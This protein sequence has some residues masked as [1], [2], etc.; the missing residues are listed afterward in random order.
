M[1]EETN[2]TAGAAPAPAPAASTLATQCVAALNKLAKWRMIL[3][4]WQVGSRSIEDETT[5][6]IRDH[7]ELTM[8]LRTE[9]NAL[10]QLLLAKGI[11]TPDEYHQQLTKEARLMENA[12][13]QRFP[14]F[15][16]TSNGML[17][18]DPALAAETTKNWKP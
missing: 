8:L 1:T 11:I 2:D 5:R 16:A 6:A 15:V 14:G 4:G 18:F 3:A 17:V 7:R 13:E 9:V 10:Q 12:L